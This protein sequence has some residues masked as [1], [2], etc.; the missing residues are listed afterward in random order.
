MSAFAFAF[1]AHRDE[2][3]AREEIAE[4]LIPLIGGL[5]RDHGVVTSIHGHRLI[6]LSATGVIE[7]HDRAR[8]LGHDELTLAQSGVVLAALR[9]IRPG[10]ASIDIARLAASLREAGDGVDAVRHVRAELA[11]VPTASPLRASA[12]VVLYGF[13]RIGRLLAR[14]L[15]SQ[16][17]S[18][19]GLRLRAIVVRR[20]SDNDL[21][22]RASLLA[23]DSVHGPFAGSVTVDHEADVLIANGTRIQVIYAD[24]PAIIDYT[25]YGIDDA[26]VVDNTGRWRDQAG[27]AQHLSSTGVSRVLLTA[28]GKAPVKNIVH[29]INDDAITQDD[30][31]LS[32]ASCTTNAITPVLAAIDEAYGVARGHVETVHSFTNDQNLTDNFHRGDRRGRSAVLNMVITETGAAEAVAKALPQ[33][34]GRL[35]GSSIRVPTPDVSLAIL[36]LT[37]E[38]PAARDEVNDYLRRVSLHS[39]LRQQI[40]Y[41]ESPEVVSSDFVGSHR[42]GIVDGLA[43]I[44]DGVNLVLYVWYDNEFGYSCQVVRVLERMAGTHA[45]VVPAR[46]EV[47]LGSAAAV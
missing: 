35:T 23:R 1:H 19:H 38:R 20:G 41:V 22:K 18:G 14:I 15:I 46:A 45:V 32:A 16:A 11:R 34:A 44:A 31:I 43:T 13:G 47:R 39:Q 26:I 17:G 2:W 24:D 7:M 36:H 29:G 3:V 21:S 6:N 33:L 10:P 25:A 12:D 9:E 40:D 8:E 28:P 37:L 27:L 30:R 4:S 5:Y 42:A